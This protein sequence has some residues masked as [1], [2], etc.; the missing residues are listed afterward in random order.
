M[1][2]KYV[3]E[4]EI[5]RLDVIDET[6]HVVDRGNVHVRLVVQDYGKTLK[7]FINERWKEE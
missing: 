2:N 5:T 6:G 4:E 1:T 7:V 3:D